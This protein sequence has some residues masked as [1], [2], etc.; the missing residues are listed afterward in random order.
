MNNTLNQKYSEKRLRNMVEYRKIYFKLKRNGGNMRTRIISTIL[1][2]VIMLGL[3]MPLQMSNTCTVKEIPVFK[4]QDIIMP[5]SEKEI[6]LTGNPNED[7]IIV[8]ILDT[9]INGFENYIVSVKNIIEN[10]LDVTD[11][12][13]HGSQ[14]ASEVLKHSHRSVRIMPVKVL[15]H[16]GEGNM[17]DIAKGIRWAVDNGADIINMSFGTYIYGDASD[18]A[19]S[20]E[21]AVGKGVLIFAAAGNYGTSIQD[22]YPASLEGVISCTAVD[23]KG[24]PVGRS[25]LDGLI[26][27]SVEE[28]QGTSYA[29]AKGT[30]IAAALLWQLKDHELVKKSILNI[31]KNDPG[32]KTIKALSFYAK[33]EDPTISIAAIPPQRTVEVQFLESGEPIRDAAVYITDSV[34]SATSVDLTVIRWDIY[35]ETGKQLDKYGETDSDGYLGLFDADEE[36]TTYSRFKLWSDVLYRIELIKDTYRYVTYI[37]GSSIESSKLVFDIDTKGFE[38]K[39]RVIDEKNTPCPFTSINLFYP[40][41]VFSQKEVTADEQGFFTLG[42][43]RDLDM[44]G[45]YLTLAFSFTNE[46]INL[47]QTLQLDRKLNGSVDLGDIIVKDS[48][49]A[50]LDA[51]IYSNVTLDIHPM[52]VNVMIFT[53]DGLPIGI[54]H[55]DNKFNSYGVKT[56][57]TY[58]FM[59]KEEE[60]YL[61]DQEEILLRPGTYNI[62]LV[63]GE[64]LPMLGDFNT[65]KW[66][67]P[68]GEALENIVLTADEVT[69]LG[70]IYLDEMP[71]VDAQFLEST[72]ITHKETVE[73]E[74]EIISFEVVFSQKERQE[75][76]GSDLSIQ[77]PDSMIILEDSIMAREKGEKELLTPTI[78]GNRITL[79]VGKEGSNEDIYGRIFFTAKVVSL[80]RPFQVTD[81]WILETNDDNLINEELVARSILK[82]SGNYLLVPKYT[83]EKTLDIAGYSKDSTRM[84]IYVNGISS[85]ECEVSSTGYLKTQLEL[86]VSEDNNEQIFEIYGLAEDGKKTRTYQVSYEPDMVVMKGIALNNT[87]YNFPED[88]QVMPLI[89]YTGESIDVEVKFSDNYLVRDVV[90]KTL[91]GG[92]GYLDYDGYSDSFKGKMYLNADQIGDVLIEYTELP[93]AIQKDDIWD[94][95]T[96]NNGMSLSGA[97]LPEAF[98][99]ENVIVEEISLDEAP[100]VFHQ[101]DA[102]KTNIYKLTADLDTGEPYVLYY[103]LDQGVTMDI[104]D[105][106]PVRLPGGLGIAYDHHVEYNTDKGTMYERVILPTA[107]IA[108][109]TF[110]A[111]D[112]GTSTVV[113]EIYSQIPGVILSQSDFMSG[114]GSAGMSVIGSIKSSFD[115]AQ[116]D[117]KLDALKDIAPD[118]QSRHSVERLQRANTINYISKLGGTALGLILP[119]AFGAPLWV[120]VAIGVG[121]GLLINYVTGKVDSWIKARIASLKSLWLIDPSGYVYEG[122]ETNFLEG[123]KTTVYYKDNDSGTFVVWNASDY[124]QKN[125]QMTS[126]DG[127]YGWDVLPGVWQ[128]KYEKDEYDTLYSEELTVPPI[129]TD[130]NIGMV[131]TQAPRVKQVTVDNYRKVMTVVLDKPIKASTLKTKAISLGD[132][133]VTIDKEKEDLIDTF[134]IIPGKFPEIGT[135]VQLDIAGDIIGYNDMNLVPYTQEITIEEPDVTPPVDVSGIQFASDFKQ[136]ILSW[137]PSPSIDT[138]KILVYSRPV[139]STDFSVMEVDS[140]A[141]S[142][143]IKDLKQDT[144]YEIR[145]FVMDQTGF[146]SFG[147]AM[148]LCTLDIATNSKTHV[149]KTPYM[150]TEYPEVNEEIKNSINNENSKE[151]L[152]WLIAAITAAL[153]AAIFVIALLLRRRKKHE[154]FIR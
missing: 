146:L 57:L 78:K 21:H 122:L 118:Q 51:D 1:I 99:P 35:S 96:M 20:I 89:T 130:V 151:Y 85:G 154:Q 63:P 110:G 116:T 15:D 139:D 30:G 106:D 55:T 32:R 50:R 95:I 71:N 19:E 5:G 38:I 58:Y 88:S 9:G 10:N 46:D 31:Y 143:R 144:L 56:P 131:S 72:I 23:I 29:S 113:Q 49:L 36:N 119:A 67:Y 34:P 142:I 45:D 13:G 53:K 75:G 2:I 97:S 74:G 14:M 125:P 141:R 62:L 37:D 101:Y 134:K 98:K 59:D 16:K 90:A 60:Y 135:V 70:D 123:V 129:H 43:P 109:G 66:L 140:T 102:K 44:I 127:Y 54:Q 115:Y 132:I 137:D 76:Y 82:S 22:F 65:M 136:I 18:L 7:A 80:D 86:S 152:K 28:H 52:D 48:S 42:I 107:L 17:E 11:D 24:I 69:H 121:V 33:N 91:N 138:K 128:V 145:I 147:M 153:L 117:A 12:N 126:G 114:I 26:A 111:Q 27:I 108:G 133:K 3:V 73:S 103:K 83:N 84:S 92:M 47:Y 77:L 124:L 149:E 112:E 93:K 8:A 120:S 6:N 64:D 81:V 148:E 94:Q 41:N 150:L 61:E 39:G 105:G 68:R 40:G 100:D 104:W 79:E 25:S 87:W 4:I